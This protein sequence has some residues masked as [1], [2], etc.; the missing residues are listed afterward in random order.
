MTARR[1]SQVLQRMRERPIDL[2]H[3]GKRVS[4]VTSEPG[5]ASGVRSLAQLYDYQWEH[6]SIMLRDGTAPRSFDILTDA[7]GLQALGAALQQSARFSMGMMGREPAYLNRV[8]SALAG[9]ADFL[10]SGA[11]EFARNARRYHQHVRENDLVL[12]H[13]LVNPRQ[14]RTLGPSAQTRTDI[15]AHV[16]KERDDGIVIA[17]ARMLATLPMSDELVVFPAGGKDGELRDSPYYFG[18]AIPSDSPGLRFI[19]RDSIDHGFRVEDYPLSARFDELDAV[20]VFHD[21]FVP[22]ERV[23]CYRD[24]EHCNA[25][26][27]ETGALQ[28]MAYQVLC[29]NIT[30]TEYLLGLTSLIVEGAGL[31]SF[32]NVHE[33]I[34]DIWLNLEMLK[35]FK[36]AAEAGAT[37]NRY[38]ALNP[39]WDPLDAARNLYP[40]LYPRM[41]EI[42]Q[43]LGASNLMAMPSHE[44]VFG[45]LAADI[46]Q[47]YRSERMEAAQRL[48]LYR[49]AWDTAVSAFGARQV[50]Y[51]RFFFGDPIQMASTLFRTKDRTPHMAAVR[52]FLDDPRGLQ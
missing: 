25:V 12:T 36:C 30:K 23:F 11:A 28:H 9:S 10:G 49:L 35:A 20:V 41:I 5:L 33:K 40:R 21:V 19:C 51:E 6:A 26:Y 42:V 13:T 45:P 37:L 18:F 29:K 14:N 50:L 22:W 32:P 31:D 43:Q 39:A 7:E 44:A 48:P 8:V 46:E 16:K 34:A 15:A 38:G 52:A 2:W 24:V 47:Y 4:D 3:R 17:G 1:G 27:R